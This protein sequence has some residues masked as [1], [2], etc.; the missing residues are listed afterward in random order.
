MFELATTERETKEL[1]RKATEL[2]EAVSQL[3]AGTSDPEL[4][5]LRKQNSKL[6]YRSLLLDQ[7]L[8]EERN[9]Q[10]NSGTSSMPKRKTPAPGSFEV[11]TFSICFRK[12]KKLQKCIQFSMADIRFKEFW[13]SGHWMQLMLCFRILSELQFCWLQLR[14]LSLATISWIMPWA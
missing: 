4:V 1:E 14:S 9:L 7:S 13:S 3:K 10:E 12:A 6:K 5:E 8:A 2:L 11:P